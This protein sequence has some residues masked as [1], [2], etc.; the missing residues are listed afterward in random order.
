MSSSSSQA[1]APSVGIV[2]N[3]TVKEEPNS[4]MNYIAPQSNFT[5]SS[6]EIMKIKEGWHAVTFVVFISFSFAVIL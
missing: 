3:L 5:D 4:S 1:V 6:A 2:S